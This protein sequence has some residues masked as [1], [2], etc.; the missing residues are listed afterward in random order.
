MNL[1]ERVPEELRS[2]TD[3]VGNPLSLEQWQQ[4]DAWAN[5]RPAADVA[6]P[7]VADERQYVLD[8]LTGGELADAPV[9]WPKHTPAEFAA[10]LAGVAE[11]DGERWLAD[12]W[13]TFHGGTREQ[14]VAFDAAPDVAP[15]SIGRP[16]REVEAEEAAAGLN[17]GHDPVVI[18]A[19]PDDSEPLPA[20]P[21]LT[22]E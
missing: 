20:G 10:M 7:P 1:D 14:V 19:D 21:P 9:W 4:I 2:H 16:A 22:D 18:V 11:N 17:D 8:C 3:H 5:P 15:P 12:V 6:P 13:E